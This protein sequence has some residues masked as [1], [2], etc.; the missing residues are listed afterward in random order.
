VSETLAGTRGGPALA[1][2]RPLPF[3]HLID[4]G[5]FRRV[6]DDLKTADPIAFPDYP[7]ALEASRESSGADE[8]VHAGAAKIG[9]HDVEVAAFDFSFLGGSMGEVAGERVAR[10]IERAADRGVPFILRSA[11]GGARMQEG[12]RSLIQMAK[13]V[14]ARAQLAEAHVPFLAVLGDPSTGGVLASV[15]ALADVTIGEMGATVGFAGPRVVET[16]T[17][18]RP[19]SDSHTATSALGNG[20]LDMV[21]DVKEVNAAIGRILDALA[22]NEPIDVAAPV[23]ASD[24]ATEPWAAVEDARADSRPSGPDLA[25]Q[26]GDPFVK[27]R[28]D[29][30]GKDDPALLAGIARVRGRRTLLLALDRAVAPGPAAYRK[31]R[32]CLALAGR[33]QVPV[34]TLVDTRGADP[35]ERSEAGG[36]AWEIAGLFDSMLSTAVPIVAVV[37]G[38][39]GSGGALAFATGDVLLAYEH[40]IFSVIGP[41]AA[42]T[43]LWRDAER[44]PDAARALR[45]TAPEL[46]RLGIA[47]HI[48]R[49]PLDADGLADAVAY[50]LDRIDHGSEGLVAARRTRWRNL[51]Y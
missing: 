11:T 29:R 31:A 6:D 33:L 46:K 28:G 39:G 12:M 32:R 36:I 47:D 22:P 1:R 23:E 51:A 45:L 44:A 35:S 9:G 37:T 38:E 34:V 5:T 2:T 15:G 7:A 3:E 50:H 48:L 17:G 16:V 14:A 25:K 42:A 21:V 4:E 30:A 43:I 19:S 10:A 49:E 8:S 13:L 24:M 20:M 18:A 27:L 40:S 26:I 41:E